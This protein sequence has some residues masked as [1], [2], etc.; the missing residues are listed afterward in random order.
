MCLIP[1]HVSLMSGW[2]WQ[3]WGCRLYVRHHQAPITPA[4]ARWH[5]DCDDCLRS[6]WMFSSVTTWR[7]FV[8]GQNFNLRWEFWFLQRD[9]TVFIVMVTH[10][11]VGVNFASLETHLWVELWTSLQPWWVWSPAQLPGHLMMP[12]RL[13]DW[14]ISHLQNVIVILGPPRALHLFSDHYHNI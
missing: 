14:K 9:Y 8:R 2:G 13:P 1:G 7:G 12:T 10:M 6:K 3:G 11:H 5:G 4:H